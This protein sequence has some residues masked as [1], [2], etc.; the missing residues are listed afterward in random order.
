MTIEEQR[1][2]LLSVLRR[3]Y[4][5]VGVYRV[6]IEFGK[7]SMGDAA[8]NEILDEARKNSALLSHVNSFVQGFEASLTLSPHGDPEGVLREFLSQFGGK[9]KPN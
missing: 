4:L 7:L 2:Y 1:D 8:V 6:F 3:L 5:E 9:Q